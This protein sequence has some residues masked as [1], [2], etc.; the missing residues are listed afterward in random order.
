[1]AEGRHERL[2]GRMVNVMVEPGS[3]P[4]VILLSG[5]GMPSYAWDPVARLLTG[6]E[7][8]RLDRPGLGGTPWPDHLPTL[9]E[10]TAT[11]TELAEA[12]PGGVFV[13]HSMASFHAEATIRRRPD[14]V[15][16]LVLVDGSIET[17]PHRPV[18]EGAWLAAARAAEW[19]ARIPPLAALGPIADRITV[20]AQSR[21]RLLDP[22]DPRSLATYSQADAV[23]SVIAESAAYRRQALDLA[24][25]RVATRWPDL[26]V[27]VITA[28]RSGGDQGVAAQR[29]LANLLG[30]RQTVLPE[31][32]H[33]VMMDE[34][35][36]IAD[37]VSRVLESVARRG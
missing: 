37:A 28:R 2:G 10:E 30:A 1:M 12:H 7:L 16:G 17:T 26:P 25:I 33:L 3:R 19:V 36:A 21:R 22:M 11:L 24:R 9:D 20:T 18:G 4:P 34:P 13:A 14:L 29:E 27:E 5:C 31:S 15:S 8:V 23:A 35:Q 32:R 6:H